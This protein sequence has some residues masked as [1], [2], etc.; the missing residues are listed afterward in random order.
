MKYVIATSGITHSGKTTFGESIRTQRPNVPVLDSDLIYSSLTSLIPQIKVVERT[1]TNYGPENPRLRHILFQNVIRFFLQNDSSVVC[2]NGNTDQHA[3]SVLRNLAHEYKA[4]F[5]LVYFNLPQVE[6][7]RRI[8]ET[9]RPLDIFT[10]CKSF[11]EVLGI[12]LQRFE[13]PITSEAD[14]FYEVNLVHD[15]DRVRE[16]ILVM[17][18]T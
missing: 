13:P 15:I 18:N 5:V 10:N 3:R 1:R 17:I 7:Q 9:T 14:I 6:I 12:Q 11:E 2:T 8:E 4:K 16:E